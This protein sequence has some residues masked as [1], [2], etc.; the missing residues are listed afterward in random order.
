MLAVPFIPRRSFAM[1]SDQEVTGEPDVI[2]ELNASIKPFSFLK[3]TQTDVWSF[4]GRVIKG[5]V[6]SLKVIPGSYLGPTINLKTGQIVKI[7]FKNKLPE[8]SIVH[9]HGLDV[10]H[11]NDGH[12]HFVVGTGED[13]TYQFKVENRAGMYWYHP[14]P[15]GR[16]GFQVYMGLVGL[17]VICDNEEKMLG[18]PSADREL[19]Y[20]IQDPVID[21]KGALIYHETARP[22]ANDTF[23]INGRPIKDANSKVSKTTVHQGAYRLRMLNGSN[24]RVFKLSFSHDVKATQIGSDGGLLRTPKSIE[25]FYFAPAER[26]DLLVDFSNIPAGTTVTLE[27]LNWRGTGKKAPVLEFVVSEQKLASYILP[28]KLSHYQDIERSE[29]VNEHAPKTFTLDMN[30]DVGWAINGK[31]YE[32]NN[33]T[34]EELIKFGDTEIW[35]FYNPSGMPHPMHIH[36]TQFQ[37]IERSSAYYTGALDLGWKDTVLVMPGDRVKVIKRF[38]TFKGIFLYHCHNLMHEDMSMMRDFKIY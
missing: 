23:I 9:W 34:P 6:D 36:G 30:L 22:I 12:P 32:H 18:L 4:D 21:K 35:E 3:G 29:A 14:H 1:G 10:S 31:G 24:G 28:A 20:V 17:M 37:V 19:T 16:T 8:K 27:T 15:H 11:P 13:Y 5:P 33:F 25:Q 26:I 7:V 38:N 2:I